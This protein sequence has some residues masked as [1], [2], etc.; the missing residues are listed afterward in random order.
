[1]TKQVFKNV[2]CRN[3]SMEAIIDTGSGI[4]VFSPQMCHYLQL[5]IKKWSGLNVLLAV[6]QKIGVEDA[7]DAEILIDNVTLFFQAFVFEIN[8]YDFLLGNDALSQLKTIKI[9]YAENEATFELG[10]IVI[11]DEQVPEKTIVFCRESCQIPA[12][13]VAK[14]RIRC[15]LAVG[16]PGTLKML[17]TSQKVM[18]DK[19]LSVRRFCYSS[20]SLPE[21]VTLVNF[22]DSP[23]WMQE[24]V[25]L[26]KFVTLQSR[27]I[28]RYPPE[29]KNSNL[30]DQSTRIYQFK[31]L[32]SNYERFFVTSDRELGSSNLVQH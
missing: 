28:H 4:P 21:V 3:Y 13:S 20:D 31:G 15:K 11:E 26:E 9:D 8:G 6:E 16:K 14:V 19:G 27:P 23:Q 2:L 1:M 7:V 25:A 30:K 29:R 5:P 22:S 32:L 24:G 12:H 18:K 17:E 10:N